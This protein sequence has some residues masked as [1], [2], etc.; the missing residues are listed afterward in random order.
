MNYEELVCL[1]N[2]IVSSYIDDAQKYYFENNIEKLKDIIE[3]DCQKYKTKLYAGKE[4]AITTW[5]DEYS[6]PDNVKLYIV[7][8]NGKSTDIDMYIG[9]KYGDVKQI[10]DFIYEITINTKKLYEIILLMIDFYEPIDAKWI[11]F[12][13]TYDR[14]TTDILARNADIFKFLNKHNLFYKCIWLERVN[15]FMQHPN[16]SNPQQLTHIER[17]LYKYKKDFILKRDKI[18]EEVILERKSSGKWTSEQALFR[19][20]KHFYPDAIYQYKTEWLGLQSLDIF[21]PSK[22]IGIEYQGIQHYEPVEYFGG[23]TGYNSVVERDKRKKKLCKLNNVKLIEWK[24][25]KE[26][27]FVEVQKLYNKLER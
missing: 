5:I 13:E 26:I 15:N 1:H 21:I 19:L 24:Y 25:T 14:K 22:N 8:P 10:D 4:N 27:T 3:A 18:Y 23:E 17:D 16:Y 12:D 20:I 2:N 11:L 9:E 6:M 7:Y